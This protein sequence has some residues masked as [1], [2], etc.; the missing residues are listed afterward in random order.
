M[1]QSTRLH[2]RFA[3]VTAAVI[4][5]AG[6]ALFWYV[7]REEVRQAERNVDQ[8]VEAVTAALADRFPD[9]VRLGQAIRVAYAEAP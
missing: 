6:I 3:V 7:E 4:A 5:T 8:A 2:L 1:A 9:R